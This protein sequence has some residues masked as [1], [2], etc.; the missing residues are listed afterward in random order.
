M[1]INQIV[2][3]IEAHIPGS[4]AQVEGDG[5]HFEARVISAEFAGKS[6]VQ[7]QQ[8]VYGAVNDYI[9]RGELHALTIKTYTP[10]EWAKLQ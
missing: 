3:L 10:E 8:L 5:Y 6:L 7:K 9:A 1:E 2:Q 4:Q